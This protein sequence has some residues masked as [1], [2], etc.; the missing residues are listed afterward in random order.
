[1]TI[2]QQLFSLF[3]PAISAGAGAVLT[4]QILDR[5]NLFY[6]KH[7]EAIQHADAA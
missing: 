3:F 2:L 6:Q 4:F 1:M 7:R 5:L